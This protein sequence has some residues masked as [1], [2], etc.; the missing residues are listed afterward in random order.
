[1]N[2]PNL[3]FFIIGGVCI[4]TVLALSVILFFNV[5][6]KRVQSEKLKNQ[7]IQISFQG[8]LLEKTIEAQEKERDR[9]SRE[10]HDDIGSKL[11]IIHLNLHLLKSNLAKGNNVDELLTDIRLAL[12]DS[13]ETSR[14]I[15]HELVPPTLQKF[16]IKSAIEDLQ[17]SVN[18]TKQI[19]LTTEYI[20]DWDIKET[21]A[22]L[23]LYRIVQELTQ[24]ALKHS[25]AQHFK[26]LF[27][28]IDQMLHLT[29]KDDGVGISKNTPLTGLGFS[30]LSTR[31]QVLKG[32]WHI[33]YEATQGAEIKISIPV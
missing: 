2:E 14:T 23:H 28:Q 8:Q 5:A 16:G 32:E 30:N 7:E 9:I 11:N 24:N 22:Q 6:Q 25:K 20:T 31:V 33:N 3:L 18:K 29:Y 10:L 27:E 26:L 1:M 17:S 19:H 4:M 21:L 12:N 15:S 13:I